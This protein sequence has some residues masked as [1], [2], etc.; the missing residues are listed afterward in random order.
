MTDNLSI[1]GIREDE[2]HARGRFKPHGKRR[3]PWVIE[4]RIKRHV[5][6]SLAHTLG[7]CDWSVH[8]RYT[9][10]ARR[11]QAYATLVKKAISF[12]QLPRYWWQW[13]YRK[14]DD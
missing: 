13:E 11:D 2:P 8:T 1:K 12:K 7:L 9:T 3:K 10:K 4:S 5:S 6:N 14:R